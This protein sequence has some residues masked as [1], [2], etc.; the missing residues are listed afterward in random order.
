MI[1]ETCSC[2]ASIKLPAVSPSYADKWAATLAALKDWRENHR[3]EFPPEPA[4]L[5]EPPHIFESNGS[6][7]ELSG[8]VYDEARPSVQLG[9]TRNEVR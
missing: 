9:F 6:A 7:V 8:I 4:A 2:S 5:E 1:E 3:H